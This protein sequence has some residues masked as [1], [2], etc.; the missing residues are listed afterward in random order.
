MSLLFSR[1]CE[2]ALQAVSYLALKPPG[3]MTSSKEMTGRLKI[4]YHFLGKI[5]QDLVYKGLLVSSKGP[6]GGFALA[7]APEHIAL[8]QVVEAIDGREFA[9]RCV[10]GFPDCSGKR[11]CAAHAHW[12]PIRERINAMLAG[13]SIAEL[14]KSMKKPMLHQK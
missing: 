4:P 1:H 5:L 2:Y 9:N 8:I 10:M 12:A 14:A 13:E 11:P 3:T 6:L 7:S